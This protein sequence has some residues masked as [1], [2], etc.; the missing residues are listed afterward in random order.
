MIA[1]TIYNNNNNNKIVYYYTKDDII[2]CYNI[3]MIRERERESER[4]TK[5]S[6]NKWISVSKLYV[7][8][9]RACKNRIAI[10]ISDAIN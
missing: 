7:G 2:L 8:I 6:K 4:E 3:I 10:T 9:L 1:S 5:T